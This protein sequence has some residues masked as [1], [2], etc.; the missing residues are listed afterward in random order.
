MKKTISVL[1]IASFLILTGQLV[2]AGSATWSLNPTSN[3]WNTA[4]NWT[5]ATVPNGPSDTATFASSSQPAVSVTDSV[6][7]NEIVFGPGASAYTISPVSA[8]RNH[9]VTLTL[10]GTGVT[11]NSGISQ[12]F[13]VSASGSMIG[14]IDFTN[15]AS[16]GSDNIY[17]IATG[18][19]SGSPVLSFHDTSTAADST[20]II[21]GHSDTGVVSEL[22]FYDQSTAQ[23]AN[24]ISRGTAL[25][26]NNS[27]AGNATV[28]CEGG[29][30]EFFD[31][32]NAG[33]A[34]FDLTTSDEGLNSIG[35][36]YSSAADATF[37][38]HSGL[39]NSLDFRSSGSATNANVTV[40]GAVS[41]GK[42]GG[43]VSFNDTSTA[44]DG[45]FT[46]KG[47]IVSDAF[48]GGSVSFE[49]ASTAGAATFELSGGMADGAPG[50]TMS[51]LG[52]TTTD[53]GGANGG[54][55]VITANGSDFSDGKGASVSFDALLT[56]DKGVSAAA[57]TLIANGGSNGGSG[58]SIS[59]HRMAAGGKA[60]VEVFGNGSLDVSDSTANALKI[61]SLQGDG[62]VYLGSRQ[63]TVGLNKHKTVFSGVIQ[64]QGGMVNGSGGSLIKAGQGIFVL[65]GANTYTG[66]T[67]VNQGTLVVGNQSGSATG[68]GSVRVN[69]TLG[70]NGIIAGPV[71]VGGTSTGGYIFPS[72][73]LPPSTLT[74]LSALT[75]KSNATYTCYFAASDTRGVHFDQITCNGVTIE[76]GATIQFGGIGMGQ[77]EPG[78]TVT[79]IN[80]TSATPIAGRFLN[81]PDGHVVY[82]GLGIYV[83][84][85]YEGGDGNDLTLT[86]VNP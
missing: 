3:D 4:A 33:N 1:A 67:T 44:G 41:A 73:Q 56:G 6:E 10:S 69:A 30:F 49:D 26:M 53:P 85:N 25:F 19:H 21:E 63:L 52:S 17:T 59:F 76:N 47:S 27:T 23:G 36:I 22:N 79:V 64:D 15:T 62:L 84:V 9:T 71:T 18:T 81:F 50:A 35:T 28:T 42:A 46:V 82:V 45:I 37:I 12:N 70:G 75:F 5:P 66:S 51:Y 38:V 60:I 31:T 68:P 55:A 32:S 86:L 16:A 34:T 43:F 57:A 65:S 83:Q 14:T 72:V 24:I 48:S 13:T 61:G 8:T 78:P 39:G 80:N 54:N 58:G 11:N 7:V 20:F 29:G 2:L 40:E 74:L 77:I